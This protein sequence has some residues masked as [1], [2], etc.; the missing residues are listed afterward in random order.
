M[1]CPAIDADFHLHVRKLFIELPTANI[2]EKV[3]ISGGGMVGLTKEKNIAIIAQAMSE[4]TFHSHACKW[5]ELTGATVALGGC[6]DDVICREAR[7][8]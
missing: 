3:R 2:I 6:E 1:I 5:F 8:F 4:N 7:D